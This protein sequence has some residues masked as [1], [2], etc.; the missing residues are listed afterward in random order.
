MTASL[1]LCL[2]LCSMVSFTV[3][4]GCA[5]Q[6]RNKQLES[7]AKDWSYVVRA[8]QVIPVYPLTEDLQPG[9]VLLVS[10]PIDEQQKL[11]EKKGF[12]PLDQ[13]LK[14]LNP[15]DYKTFYHDRYGSSD[16][17][18]LP[19]K[20]Q[21]VITDG[22]VK[23]TQ[24]ELAPNVAFPPYNFEVSTGS[25]MNLAIP[26]QGVPIALGMMNSAKA[27]GA[28]TIG[29]SYTYGLD[30]ATLK[31][32]V[33]EWAATNRELLRWYR[34]AEDKNGRKRQQ[35]LRVVSRVYVISDIDVTVQNDEAASVELGGGA[36]KEIALP[37]LKDKAAAQ[38]YQ[39]SLSVFNNLLNNHLPGGKV[40][41]A[42]ASSR[43]VTL[44]EHFD[45]PLV[46]GYVGF[47]LPILEGGRLGAPIST[48]AQLTDVPVIPAA[49]GTNGYRLAAFAHMNSALQ[50]ITGPE[51]DLI[52]SNLDKLGSLLPDTYPFTMYELASPTEV[53]K[54]AKIVAGAKISRRDFR[55]VI[56]YL[57]Y[58]NKTVETLERY[59]ATAKVDATA[60]KTMEAD[61]RAAREAVEKMDRDFGRQPALVRAVDF[62]F[63]GY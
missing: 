37:I 50:D 25:G 3:L 45:R 42:S 9:D 41:V 43:S 58:G 44:N 39:D 16:G 22:N 53:R 55:G 14:R 18:M 26:I 32:S 4:S 11:Y 27:K 6:L 54:S 29:R 8:S 51:A 2:V 15:R 60:R 47:D 31:A 17:N 20:W 38:N 28:V 56:D 5:S 34:P 63:L 33:D 12:L 7:V 46:I 52:K 62:V 30:N 35:F 1:R 61:L 19:A 23:K 48:L 13:L 10:T 59:L 21:E 57:G 36:D 24:W 49:E 40:K